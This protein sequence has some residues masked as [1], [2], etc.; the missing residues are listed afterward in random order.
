MEP[1]QAAILIPLLIVAVTQM[2]KML[3]PT[4]NGW[5][6]IIV[7]LLIGVIVAL[8]HAYIGVADISVAQGLILALGAIGVSVLAKK[9]ASGV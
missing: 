7:A 6:T 5:V 3:L 2:I 9:S 4:V 8:T 1:V